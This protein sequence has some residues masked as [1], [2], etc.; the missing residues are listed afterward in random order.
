MKRIYPQFWLLSA[1]L[2][3]LAILFFT[4]LQGQAQTLTVLHD[5][6]GGGDGDTP[7]AGLTVDAAGNLYGTTVYGGHGSGTVFKLSRAGSSWRLTPLYMFQGGADGGYPQGGVVFG[8]DGALY[9]ATQGGGLG[10]GTVFRL[11][12]SPRACASTLCPWTETV[13]Y[14]FSGQPDGAYPGYG[15]L[16]FDRSGNIYGTTANGGAGNFGIVF[17]LS[18]SAQG[19]TESILLDFSNT[20][21]SYPE[22]GLIFDSAGNLYGTTLYGDSSLGAVYELSHSQSGWTATTLAELNVNCGVPSGGVVM[23]AQ[24]NLFGTTGYNCSG[25]AYELSG[26]QGTWAVNVLYSFGDSYDG[27]FDTPTLDAAGNVYGTSS[28]SGRDGTGQIFELIRSADGWIFND[29]FEFS[30]TNNSP[31]FP[32]GGVAFDSAGNLYGTT[33]AGGAHNRG[34]VWE[35]TP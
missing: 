32:I 34:V 14:R 24:G 13:L 21:L 15:N 10:F 31:A 16:V 3:S 6:T 25:G 23:D 18:H 17:E 29:L 11:A 4:G 7:Y 19:W 12:P 5:F 8:P 26:L 2:A 22:S 27:P 1:W 30:D 20:Q 33:S 28:A 35:I 9:G